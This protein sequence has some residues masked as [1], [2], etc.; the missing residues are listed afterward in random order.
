MLKEL[1][2]D[3][4][5]LGKIRSDIEKGELNVSSSAGAILENDLFEQAVLRIAKY[6]MIDVLREYI[7]NHGKWYIHEHTLLEAHLC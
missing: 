2:K 5:G 3:I 4:K 1:N 6:D 7:T